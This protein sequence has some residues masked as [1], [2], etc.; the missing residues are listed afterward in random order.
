MPEASAPPLDPAPQA[1]TPAQRN[2]AE[3]Y[4]CRFFTAFEVPEA[5]TRFILRLAQSAPSAKNSQPWKVV[6]VR[7]ER[8][9]SLSRKLLAAAEHDQHGQADYAHS[10]D[11]LPPI[12]QERARKVGFELYRLKGIARDDRE[13]RKEHFLENYR[14]FGA[15]QAFI[16]GIER[17]GTQENP[18]GN[19]LDAGMFVQSLWLAVRSCGY[20]ACAQYSVATYAGL[21]RLELELPA[22]FVVLCAMP[23]GQADATALVNTFR[24]ERA[25]LDEWVIFRG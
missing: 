12:Q 1:L 17:S 23:F 10:Y 2:L 8:L 24:T 16:L 15:P 11:P 21:I 6:V 7:A 13:K 4:S 18:K 9:R 25:P 5:E 22:S 3:R 14:F 19:F 20:E